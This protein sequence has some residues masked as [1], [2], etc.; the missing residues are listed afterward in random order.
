MNRTYT[1]YTET[2]WQNL[3][4]G[5]YKYAVETEFANDVLSD[6]VESNSIQ[7]IIDGIGEAGA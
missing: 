6:L 1:S 5:F 2:E 3:E 4:E 7:K